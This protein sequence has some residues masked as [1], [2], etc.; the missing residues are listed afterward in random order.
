MN[1]LEIYTNNFDLAY[2][3][4]GT[5]FLEVDGKGNSFVSIDRCLEYINLNGVK[6]D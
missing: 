3:V 1:K 2:G 4:S 6:V 5:A